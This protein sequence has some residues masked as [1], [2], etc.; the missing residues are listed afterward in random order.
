LYGIPIRCI[1]TC[2]NTTVEEVHDEV[3]LSAGKSG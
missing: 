1:L 2:A 3:F